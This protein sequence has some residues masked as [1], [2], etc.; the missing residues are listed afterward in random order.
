MSDD[1]VKLVS[2]ANPAL[3][4]YQQTS[5]GYP[6]S[7][8]ADDHHL[9]PF[10]DDDDDMPDIALGRQTPMQSQAS[11]LPLTKVAAPPAGTEVPQGWSWDDE[12]PQSFSTSTPFPGPPSLDQ[13]TEK[14]KRKTPRFKWNWPWQRKEKVLTGE[15]IVALNN[16]AANSEFCSNYVSTSKYNLATF[17]PKFLFGEYLREYRFP[18]SLFNGIQS[19]SQNMQTCFS[20]SLLLFNKYPAYHLRINTLQLPLYWWCCWLQRIRRSQRTWLVVSI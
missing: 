18:V 17:L 11:G 6:P 19:N 3:S 13:T 2:Q 5:N 9:D 16:S 1:F 8:S 20:C 12:D 4:Q 14:S 15:R 7:L 10:F